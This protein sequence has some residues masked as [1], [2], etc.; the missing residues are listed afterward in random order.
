MTRLVLL[1][2]P[3]TEIALG[4]GGH[5]RLMA[6]GVTNLTILRDDTS[7]AVVLEGWAFDPSRSTDRLLEQIG[8]SGDVRV[9]RQLIHVAVD[10]TTR[11]AR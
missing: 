9:L 11:E 3:D 7:L 1:L 10:A 8:A 4:P 5:E 6:L 2:R